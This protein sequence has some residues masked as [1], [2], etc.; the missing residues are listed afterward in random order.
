VYWEDLRKNPGTGWSLFG[1]MQALKAQG[2]T[3]EAALAEK[4]FEKAWKEADFRLPP[5]ARSGT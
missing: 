1:L 4:R 2:K 5:A 3:D